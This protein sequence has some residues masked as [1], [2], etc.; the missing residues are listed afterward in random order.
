MDPPF[1]TATWFR[2]S[3][4]RIRKMLKYVRKRNQADEAVLMVIENIT[5]MLPRAGWNDYTIDDIKDIPYEFPSVEILLVP[6][7]FLWLVLPFR[8]L[9]RSLEMYLVKPVPQQGVEDALTNAVDEDQSR[10]AE[11]AWFSLF[12]RS[13]KKS[14]SRIFETFAKNS[15]HFY[16]SRDPNRRKRTFHTNAIQDGFRSEVIA[17]LPLLSQRPLKLCVRWTWP[18]QRPF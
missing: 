17:R 10:L 8:L 14:Y 16:H 7:F 11:Y 13:W 12:V 18:E 1:S 6:E 2:V 15:K 3:T 9:R 4:P 5:S